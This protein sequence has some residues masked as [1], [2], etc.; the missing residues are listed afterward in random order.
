MLMLVLSPLVA[1]GQVVVL[2]GVVS[3][4][5]NGVRLEFAT[6]GI[7]GTQNG[8]TTDAGGHYTLALPAGDSVTVRFSFT[9]YEP[10]EYRMMLSSDRTL[11]VRLQPSTR[12][13]DAVE[14][15]DEKTRHSS[16]TNIGTEKLEYTVG[17]AG[18]VESL[19]K[20]L[21]DVNSNNE[22]SSQYSVRGGSFDENLVYINGIEV[23]RPMLI[24][25]GQQEGLSI[26]NADMVDYILFSP[27]GFDASYGDKLSSVLD[28]T[29]ARPRRFSAKFNVSLL[30][31]A[32]TVMDSPTDKFSYAVGFRRHSNS[33]V[34]S[35]LDTRG[36]YS[37]V[38]NDLQFTMC[39]HPSDRTN[40]N[41][42]GMWTDNV[43]G[44]V[45]ESQVTSFGSLAQYMQLEIW[46]DGKEQDRYR[47]LL[48][49]VSLDHQFSDNWKMKTTFSLQNIE[50][51]E[52]YDV[53]SQYF[54][55]EVGAGDVVGETERFD[56]GVGTFLEHASNRLYTAI[57]AAD[58]RFVRYARLGQ[59]EFG[60]KLQHE[61]VADHLREW[62]WV[63]SAGYSVPQTPPLPGDTA[64]VPQVP[65]LQG[66]TN[67][68]NALQTSRAM[69]FLQRELNL[70]IHNKA[71]IKVL[72]GIRG[73]VYSR[74]DVV[75]VHTVVSPRVSVSCKPYW[76]KDILFRL[77]GGVYSQPPFYREYR[78]SDGTLAS[79]LDAQKTYQAVA[80]VDWGLRIWDKPFKFT[81]DIYYKYIDNLVPYI[82]DNLRLRYFPDMDAKGYTA[83][84]SL[85]LNG[86]IVEGLESW[87]S[88]SLM[89]AR[90]DIEGD[91]LGWMRRPTDQLVSFKVFMQDNVP[92]IPWWKMSLS[93]IY[94]SPLPIYVPGY[95][96]SGTQLE[97][98]AYFRVDWGNT[99]EILRFLPV[100]STK[101]F[102]H[103][104]DI[105]IGLEV[106]NLFNYR[107]TI[108]YL[109][110]SDYEGHPFRVPNYLTSR[111]VNVK[112]SVIF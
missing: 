9:G 103:V 20:T 73:N 22:L 104:K 4:R 50:E 39:Y 82:V 15:S 25:N 44:L 32:A 66:F 70:Y 99:V 21:P 110:V 12:V 8:T 36:S 35:S 14:I 7:P 19:L 108:S 6:V 68:E 51:S 95:E 5:V 88:L 48:G 55:Y 29:Y 47:T 86:E 94:G 34:L 41:V 89:R 78:C 18:G 43:Y 64:S 101:I 40:V 33:Y 97:I 17:P 75:N 31:G 65:L 81:A 93:L 83:G 87:A 1:T 52:R 30:G 96:F 107:N 16:F 92:Q 59:W 57:Y 42:L 24:R 91:G 49:A 71:D 111:R 85:R 27:G 28:I 112:L 74:H 67:A 100:A 37:T 109:W 58:M 61:R 80:S 98:P 106:F 2:E 56:R 3:D 23:F 62:R 38:Y 79:D 69:F 54:L 76:K 60:V 77:A 72:A 11:D 84:L 90:E 63:D 10:Q 102:K 26:I 46:F 53:Q 13:L 45:P 105:Q